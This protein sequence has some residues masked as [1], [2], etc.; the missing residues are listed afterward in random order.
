MFRVPAAL[1]SAGVTVLERRP[2]EAWSESRGIRGV[3]ADSREVGP[4]DL[5]V[6]WAG[7]THDAHDHLGQAVAAGAVAAVVERPVPEAG[8][9]HPQGG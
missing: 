7:G 1:E 5:F 6:A 4:G 9:P 8:L 3:R 2:P